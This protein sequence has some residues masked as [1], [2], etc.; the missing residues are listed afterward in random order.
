MQDLALGSRQPFYQYKLG[1]E[2]TECSP[3]EKDLGVLVNE[4]LDV[5]QQC[6]LT[7]P[8][9]NHILGCIKRN[10]ASRERDVILPLYSVLV[11]PHLE[12]SIQM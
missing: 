5:S 8:K 6:A 11:K 4:K 10:E 3:A 9:G 7:A 2:R 12:H 1:D